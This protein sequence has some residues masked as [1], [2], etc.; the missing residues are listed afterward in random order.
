MP[1]ALSG[2][3]YSAVLEGEE[4]LNITGQLQINVLADDY[5]SIPLGLRGGVLARADLDGK[6]AQLKV[7]SRH[8]GAGP[9]ARVKPASWQRPWTRRS[10]CCKFPAKEPTSWSWKCD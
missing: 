9:A 3:A 4:T 2:A 8:A 7:V 1:Y 10:S 6:P 5:V